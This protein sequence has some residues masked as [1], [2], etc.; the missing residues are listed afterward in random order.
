MCELC[1]A[2]MVL[3]D[4]RAGDDHHAVLTL[5]TGVFLLDVGHVVVKCFGRHRKP[6]PSERGNAPQPGEHVLCGKDVVGDGKNVE[7]FR[8]PVQV[9]DV[10][11]RQAPVAPRRV[12]MEVAEQEGLVS[13]HVMS[14]AYVTME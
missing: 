9:D 3:R 2:R 8:L 11:Q 5:R 7:P 10:A 1:F 13:R 4:L 14:G 6:P 12:Y